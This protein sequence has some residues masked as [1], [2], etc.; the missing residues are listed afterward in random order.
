MN[1]RIQV[2]HGVT[3][4]VTGI[5]IVKE[6]LLIVSGNKLTYSQEEIKISGYAIEARVYA[7]NPLNSFIPVSG[8]LVKIEFPKME[9]SRIDTHLQLPH[10]LPAEYD[11]LLAKLIGFGESREMAKKQLEFLLNNTVLLGLPNTIPFLVNLLNEKEYIE[12]QISTDF[13]ENNYNRFSYKLTEQ[14]VEAQFFVQIFYLIYH[15]QLKKVIPDN[16]WLQIGNLKNTQSLIITINGTPQKVVCTN[17]GEKINVVAGN[18]QV[19]V[20]KFWFKP[21]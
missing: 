10:H 20:E 6:Q 18:K 17:Y 2:E 1:T 21:G 16:V 11:A 9:G 8:E 3:E 19:L 4:K 12:N 7:E 15:F 13:I 14:F 5:D